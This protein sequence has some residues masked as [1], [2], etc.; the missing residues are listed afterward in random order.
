MRMRGV[1]VARGALVDAR[2]SQSVS[3]WVLRHVA[4]GG[5]V[6][7]RGPSLIQLHRDPR[8]PAVLRLQAGHLPRRASHLLD[9]G[10]V[11]Q[12]LPRVETLCTVE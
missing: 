8:V 2:G 1:W 12:A 3:E 5:G 6:V 7:V 10:P 11:P 9:E 4:C